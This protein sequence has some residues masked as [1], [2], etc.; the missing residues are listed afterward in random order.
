MK[1]SDYVAQFLARHV[2]HVYCVSGSASLHLIHSIAETPGID[3]VCPQHEQAGAFAA[4]AYARFRGGIGCVVT[5]SGP[6]ATNLATGIAAAFQDSIPVLYITGQV[7]TARLKGTTGVRALG[8][9]ET[10]IVKIVEPITKHAVMVSDP[11]RIR[12]EL[13][14]ALHFATS[15]RPGP[16]LLDIPDDVQRADI[17]PSE[18]P[19]YLPP[20]ERAVG[21]N[22]A[23]PLRALLEAERPVIVLGA[24][25]HA[26]R[27]E[28]AARDLVEALGAPVAL[29]WGGLDLLPHDHPL[30]VGGFGTHG[31]RAA[32]LAVQNADFVLAI[33]ARLDTKATGAPAA[34]FARGARR[35]AVDVDPAELG[36]FASLG[37]EVAGIQADAGAFIRALDGAAPALQYA[38]WRSC[39]AEWKRLYPAVPA[40]AAE[41]VDVDPYHLVRRLGAAMRADDVLVADTGYT[42]CWLAQAFPFRGQRFL[43]AFG[44]T[45]MGWG[46]P[47]AI[48]A[49]QAGAPRAV[50]VTG[51]GSFQMSAA[52]LATIARHRL[53]VKIVLLNNGGHG[54]C[55]QTQR[56]WLG[57]KYFSTSVEG[58]LGFPDFVKLAKAHGIPAAVIGLRGE[59]DFAL[60]QLF[61]TDGPGLLEVAIPAEAELAH[62]VPFG[63]ALDEAE[64]V[65]AVA[66]AA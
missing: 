14:R 4:D 43:H 20:V 57:G 35:F 52:E 59:I 32:N 62:Q 40:G 10:E 3:Y 31:T 26:A 55:R 24:G 13:E 56:R 5:T 19:P 22:V 27:A 25:V 38:A 46:L 1:L 16:V 58:G 41:A 39:I 21:F 64:P 60:R 48:G 44:F 37:L 50:L 36:K 12:V 53:P 9:Q 8:F 45:P 51:D 18:L 29:T 42:V 11:R 66:E 65:I 7:P 6:G 49:V 2:Q 63:K 47:G 54:M 33:G 17:E 23:R 61:A 30:N 28:A 15:G 34:S